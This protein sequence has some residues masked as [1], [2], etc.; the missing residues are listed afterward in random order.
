MSYSLSLMLAALYDSLMQTVVPS[1][2]VQMKP[3]L[4]A[5]VHCSWRKASFPQTYLFYLP[6]CTAV[7]VRQASLELS[8]LSTMVHCSW[9]K[10]SFP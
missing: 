2:F 9:S 6:W 10:A 4:S 7:G 1:F 5:M 8:V 3:V